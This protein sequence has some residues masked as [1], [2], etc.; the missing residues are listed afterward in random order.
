MAGD[1]T[2][3]PPPDTRPRPR[4]P[5]RLG[6]P[7]PRLP[8]ADDL[9]RPQAQLRAAH[10]DAV[11]VAAE[12]RLAQRATAVAATLVATMP[13]PP[14]TAEP[15]TAVRGITD[16]RTRMVER[17]RAGGIIEARVLEAMA[18]VDRHRFVDPAFGSQAYEDTSLPIGH[19]QT[20]SKPSV[21][22]RMLE[23]LMQG[24]QA[25][26]TGSIGCTLE[27]GTGC[28]Y[29]AAVLCRLA[30][31]VYSIERIRALHDAAR[32]NLEGQ[33]PRN[34][35]LVHG[36]GMLGHAPNAPYRSIVSAAGG[37]HVPAAW[38]DQL[39]VGGRLVA[40]T[41]DPSGGQ[42][43]IVIDRTESGYRHSRQDPVLFVPLKSGAV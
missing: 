19:G 42:A 34:L 6:D 43:L 10:E 4:F 38:L 36:D 33:R 39:A 28:G 25:R 21:V 18:L 23:L 41:A 24:A 22:A 40:P 17:L 16:A 37:D 7:A 13:A 30:S 5:A 2:P 9:L 15:R 8:R 26:Q 1:L 29:Q 31:D 27:I 35:R 3:M 14:R 20:I 32:L 11:A 12:P